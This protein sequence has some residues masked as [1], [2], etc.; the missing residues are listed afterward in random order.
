MEVSM[1][2]VGAAT[3]AALVSLLGLIIGKE[4]KTSEFRQAWVDALRAEI[5]EYS[6]NI[7]ILRDKLVAEYKTYN[8]KIRSTGEVYER[9]NKASYAIKLRVNPDEPFARDLLDAMTRFEEIAR[10][11][12]T[13]TLSKINPIDED[14]NKAAKLLLKEE[15]KT[16]KK[17]EPTFRAAKAITAVIFVLLVGLISKLILF[18]AP[19]R[20]V[21][22]S[23]P[24][25]AEESTN[26][27]VCAERGGERLSK[28]SASPAEIAQAVT[29]SCADAIAFTINRSKD[30]DKGQ[31]SQALMQSTEE[32]AFLAVIE[33]RNE[34]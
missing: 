30:I 18:D 20:D 10:D 15:W 7:R 12:K 31:L 9:L 22:T 24:V 16:V 21:A 27:E 6:S 2:A 13:F 14:F 34:P 5:I 32:T 1:G 25:L 29:T 11:D 19:N 33:G 28:S 17:G 8:E 3:I 4:Q 26:W 23:L